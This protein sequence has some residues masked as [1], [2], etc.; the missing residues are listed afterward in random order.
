MCGEPS[1]T[2]RAPG[3]RPRIWLYTL[4]SLPGNVL[5]A[6]FCAS[7]LRLTQ[8]ESEPRLQSVITSAKPAS[9]PP[10]EIVTSE[11]SDVT[12]A[13]WLLSTSL[14]TAPEQ[15]TNAND[16][17]A[18]ALAHSCAYALALRLQLPLLAELQAERQRGRPHE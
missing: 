15:A 9:L 1:T 5:R 12:E 2:T 10:M 13:T 18:F 3:A 4:S 16:D 7:W 14:V 6:K 11:V 17:G 8:L